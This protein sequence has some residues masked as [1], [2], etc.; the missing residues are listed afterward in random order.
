MSPIPSAS[1]VRDAGDRLDQT[2]RQRT[3]LG[4]PEM[5]RVIGRL[6]QQP[7]RVDHQRHVRRLDRDLHVVEVD[8]A[9]QIELVH[10]R[11]DERL[12]RDAAVALGHGRVER[13]RVHADADRQAAI[14]RLGRDEL[15]VLGL[16]DVAGVQPQ[17]LHPGLDRGERELVLEVDVG[18][19]RHRRA[20][21]DLRRGPTAA[22]S[23]LHVQRTMSAP[24]AAERVDLRQRA[25]DVGRLGRRHRLDRHR[26]VAADGHVA[27]HHLAGPTSRGFAPQPTAGTVPQTF[28]R[29]PKPALR[30]ERI[31]RSGGRCRGTSTREDEHQE[32]EH[33]AP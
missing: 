1:S 18:D 11:R 21:H 16:A 9:E 12:G 6:R 4:D 10:R 24:A 30:S 14:L 20:G 8:L 7:V 17:R 23:S 22:S 32:H 31:A 28:T 13:A 27:D 3:G 15:D 33:H 26:G 5:Q 29:G 25:V 19:D 2:L